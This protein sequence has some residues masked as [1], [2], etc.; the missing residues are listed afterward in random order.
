MQS[1]IS[2]RRRKI[3]EILRIENKMIDSQE[4]EYEISTQ[5]DEEAKLV[6]HGLHLAHFR[7]KRALSYVT[8]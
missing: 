7:A 4:E 3:S 5:E 8:K 6:E 2:K 1:A